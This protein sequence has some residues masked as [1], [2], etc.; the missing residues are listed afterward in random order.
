MKFARRLKRVER[1]AARSKPE[2]QSISFNVNSDV[3]ARGGNPVVNGV[4]FTDITTIS[5][6]DLQYNRTGNRIRVWRVEFRGHMTGLL[7]GYLL[8][9][10]GSV[11]PD[12]N[13]FGG[14]SVGQYMA[15]GEQNTRFTEWKN[16]T[17]RASLNTHTCRIK[18][19]QKFNGMIVKY[20][21]DSTAAVN[22][23]LV[24]AFVNTSNVVS[25]VNGTA[26]IWYTDH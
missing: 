6:G 19:A 13:T 7:D 26:R 3:A 15:S 8:Q 23:G 21:G 18:M 14:S 11:N 4:Q 10:H 17:Q 16:F 25:N 5:Q 2:M 12:T 22:N 20:D 1:V 24:L 9:K